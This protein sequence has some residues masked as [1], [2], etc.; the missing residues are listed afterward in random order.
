MKSQDLQW[1]FGTLY[2]WDLHFS[3]GIEW[4]VWR[5]AF[6]QLLEFVVTILKICYRLSDWGRSWS[7][8]LFLVTNS[9][10]TFIKS[11][12]LSTQNRCG[13]TLEFFFQFSVM[14]W[15]AGLALLGWKRI[16]SPWSLAS[17]PQAWLHLRSFLSCR[18]KSS[19]CLNKSGV[20]TEDWRA[21]DT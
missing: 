11:T 15:R 20:F 19:F 8:F 1:W 10:K 6:H 9:L 3:E 2:Q 21:F 17:I 4:G 14:T 13:I 18:G 12:P 16:I 7:G 5:T